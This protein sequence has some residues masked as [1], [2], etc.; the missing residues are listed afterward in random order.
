MCG[1]LGIGGS[2]GPHLV[3][4]LIGELRHRGPDGEGVR[5]DPALTLGHR[6]LAIIGPD[7]GGNQP[8]VS[9]SGDSVL[10]L[11]GEIYNYRELAD[12]LEARGKVPDRRYDTAVLLAGL[13]TWGLDLLPRLDGMFAFAWYRP[14]AEQVVLARDRWGKKPLFWGRIRLDDGSRVLA[15]AS[16]LRLLARLPGGPPAVDPLGVARYLVYDGLAGTHTIYRGIRKLAAGSWMELDAR[17]EVLA[18][19]RYFTFTPAPQPMAAGPAVVALRERLERAVLWRLRSDVPVGLFLSG[20]IDS[21]T[22]AALWR[23]LRP[24]DTIRTF[25]VG[26]EEDSFDERAS[27]RVMARAIGAEHREVVASGAD[28][29]QALEDVWARLSEPFADPSIVPTA[30]LCRFAREHVSVV[31]G[32]DGADEL[33]AGY[34]PFRAWGPSRLLEL[35]VPRRFWQRALARLERLLP[36]SP[37]NNAL[38]FRVRH[39]AQGFAHPP[40]ERVQG[41]MAS[42]P[43][44]LALT[45][46]KPE[47]VAEL[48]VEAVLEP[49]RRAFRRAREHGA[50]YAQIA[51]WVETYL[52]CSILTKVDRASMLHSLEVRAPFLAPEVAGLLSSLPPALI[53]RRGHG[54]RLLRRLAGEL[55]PAALMHK[56]KKGLG[57]PQA[58]WLRTVL[59]GRVEAA[60]EYARSGGWFDHATIA[61]LWHEHLAGRADYR[62]SLWSFVLASPF[63]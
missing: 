56:P 60:L 39:L 30:L 41:W 6:R 27:A 17:G 4:R 52:E 49:S 50:L 37:A 44:A 31:L 48:E 13:E 51:T 18:S 38:R 61:H 36:P 59:R 9:A 55:L 20:G 19:R 2:R 8:M 7:A 43:L 53:F 62:R 26:F 34:D 58:D 33:Q 25:T 1:I 14:A 29:T 32:G 23:H 22:L 10:V 42:L 35:L 16:E 54:K 47:L 21:S 11:N 5:A 45:A 12:A 24:D 3:R 63:Q 15:F 28:L 46:M 40:E 57:V